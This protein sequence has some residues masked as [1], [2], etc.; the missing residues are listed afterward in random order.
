MNWMFEQ[1]VFGARV[2]DYS[3]AS[4]S[5]NEVT[6]P[7]GVFDGAGGGKRTVTLEDAEKKDDAKDRKKMYETVIKLRREGDAVAPVECVI[8]FK[9]GSVERRTW[10]GVYRWAKFTIVKGSEVER[11]EIDPQGK[12]YMD[13]NWS[14]D[15][16]KAKPDGATVARW[17]SNI[18]FYAQN[19]AIWIGA[20]V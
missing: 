3:V 15:V 5:S 18:L 20:L 19:A 17:L 16:W 12:Y 2:L 9:D 7:F 8:R 13:V 4:V 11:V 14:N 10:D 1:F 6:T